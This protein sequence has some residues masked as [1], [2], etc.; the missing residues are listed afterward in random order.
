M[1][2]DT[3]TEFV[4]GLTAG[5]SGVTSLAQVKSSSA[6]AGI[7]YATGAGGTGTQSTNKTTTTTL[8]PSACICGT[9]TT[10]NA[11]LGSATIVSF[12]VTNTAV[13][14]TD[15]VIAN[16]ISGGTLGGYTVNAR[17]GSGKFSIDL[18]NNTGGSLSE[19]LVI[20]F[21]VIKGVTS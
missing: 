15:L 21:A 20:A 9:V 13:A 10:N 17:A 16:H 19:A 2:F 4:Q 7:G 5:S 12:D 8:T 14:T 6:T 18:R 3:T 11:A 1:A